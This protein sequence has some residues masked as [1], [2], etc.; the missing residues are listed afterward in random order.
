MV[1]AREAGKAK[2]TSPRGA[3]MLL[4]DDVVDLEGKLM[5]LLG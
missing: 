4:R 1:V 2:V 3:A 5:V